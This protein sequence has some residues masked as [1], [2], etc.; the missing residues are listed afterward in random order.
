METLLLGYIAGDGDWFYY[1]RYQDQFERD[2]V[3]NRSQN[4]DMIISSSG[5]SVEKGLQLSGLIKTHTGNTKAVC[6]GFVASI[7]TVIAVSADK[8][9]MDE[10]STM[11]IHKVRGGAIGTADE[12]DKTADQMRGFDEQIMS[13]YIG[14]IAKNG[15]L[16]NGKI[17][18]TRKMLAA[19][20]EEERVMSAN[21]CFEMGLVDKVVNCNIPREVEDQAGQLVGQIENTFPTL[22][23][24]F[25]SFRNSY[26]K[27]Q[28][29]KADKGVLAGLVNGIKSLLN[30]VGFGFKNDVELIETEP[31]AIEQPQPQEEQPIEIQSQ[32]T[33]TTDTMTN[34]EMIEQ[35]KAQGFNVEKIQN[36]QPPVVEEKSE[37]EK[38]R[39]DFEA[40]EKALNDKLAALEN[41]TKMRPAGSGE[42][43]NLPQSKEEKQH[44]LNNK[45]EQIGKQFDIAQLEKQMR[46]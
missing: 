30:S 26:T 43:I 42:P 11:L 7:A 6:V 32:T 27:K 44:A 28:P 8:V 15:K 40:K 12:M 18:D 1:N 25:A 17:E 3:N 19:C 35:L 22:S 37:L 5:G 39:A 4:I 45:F 16:V 29:K 41:A 34:E 20:M 9:V 2:L 38:L 14:R 10:N 13:Y 36:Q 24:H 33:E 21:E 46:K 31:Q 23:N